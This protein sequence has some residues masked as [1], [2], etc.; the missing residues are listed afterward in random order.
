MVGGYRLGAREIVVL[1]ESSCRFYAKSRLSVRCASSSRGRGRRVGH[2]GSG[3]GAR[4]SWENTIGQVY[5]RILEQG[6][7]YIS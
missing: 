5:E 7:G 1:L 3:R 4:P 6:L 2:A